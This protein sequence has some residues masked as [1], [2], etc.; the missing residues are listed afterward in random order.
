MTFSRRVGCVLIGLWLM[1]CGGSDPARTPATP[2]PQP[3]TLELPVRFTDLPVPQ[4]N[5]MTVTGVALGRRLFFDPILSVDSTVACGSCHLPAFAFSDTARFSRGVAGETGRQS[6]SL[7][8]LAW[9]SELFWDG[10]AESLE[11]QVLMPVADPVEMGETWDNVE[12]KLSSHGDYPALFEAAFPGE[13]ITRH[14]VAR[15]IAQYERTLISGES[16]FDRFLRGDV[17]FTEQELLGWTVYGTERGDCFHCHGTVLL[18]DNRFHN[19]GLDD[20]PVDI[21]HAEVSG[22]PNDTG[23]F[24]TPTLRNVEVTPP[25]MHDGRFASLEQVLDH[26]DGGMHRSERLDPLLLAIPET[27]V[28]TVDERL[29]LL[30]FL[31]T[32]TD[33][34]FLEEHVQ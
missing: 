34:V 28:L 6:M 5:P 10:R 1:A 32:L 3:L 23:H 15:A 13:P 22:N 19:N 30:A 24:R 4:D 31:K 18:T 21:G 2:D 27:R 25:Y 7:A 8:N 12:R 11:A 33:P 16:R 20:V 14:H 17:E 26:Y 29:A 9:A